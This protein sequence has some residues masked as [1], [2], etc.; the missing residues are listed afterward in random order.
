MKGD[1]VDV[2]VEWRYIAFAAAVRTWNSSTICVVLQF[3]VSV[4]VDD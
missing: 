3:V 2:F 4:I 1:A